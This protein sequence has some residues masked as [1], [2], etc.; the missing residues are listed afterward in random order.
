M[1]LLFTLTVFLNSFLLFL[2]EP[3]IA[4]RLLPIFGGS[5]LV[6]NT[7]LLFFQIVLVLGYLWAH[8][9]FKWFGP[10]RQPYAHLG[11]AVLPLLVMP[12]HLNEG[13]RSAYQNALSTNPNSLAA[14][15][16][17]MLLLMLLAS[18]GLPFFALS[19]G[20]PIIQR[21]FSH[22]DDPDAHNPYF[23]YAASN[24][25]SILALVFY[26]A[27]FERELGLSGQ[28]LW[29]SLG[30]VCFAVLLAFAARRGQAQEGP[31]K[32]DPMRSTEISWTQ[33]GLWVLLAAGPSALLLGVTGYVT[34]NIA[35]IPLLWV[36]PLA[37]YL[38][39]FIIVFGKWSERPGKV[40]RY[41]APF[42]A[43]PAAIMVAE[44][45]PHA[46][47]IYLPLH[48]VALFFIALACHSE[49]SLRK[50]QASHLTEFF[51]WVSI[52]GAVGGFFASIVAPLAL[53]SLAEYPWA[54]VICFV[55]I[56][57]SVK[58]KKSFILDAAIPLVAAFATAGLAKYLF[59]HAD[60]WKH[61][62]MDWV[63]LFGFFCLATSLRP[64]R[65]SLTLGAMLL[66]MNIVVER[67]DLIFRG[68]SFYGV[69]YV[70]AM[71]SQENPIAHRLTNGTT[72]HGSQ[73][74]NPKFQGQPTTYYS[75]P[76]GV[77]RAIVKRTSE[78]RLRHWAVVGLGTGTLAAYG[79]K[80]ESLDYYELDPSIEQIA[81]NP[82]LFTYLQN[83]QA[84]S[85]VLIGDARL[86]LTEIQ[87]GTYDLIALDAFA[88]DAIPVHLLTT[89]AFKLYERD[90]RADGWLLVH[91]SNR[92][93]D[94]APVVA[95]ICRANGLEGY[96]YDDNVNGKDMK[97]WG[98]YSNVLSALRLDP[99][100]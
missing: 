5:A 17:V 95:S 64:I 32:A 73:W 19:A 93:L 75:P 88:S 77:G 48:F 70:S 42:A 40:V 28:S 4:K 96:L 81:R 52:G 90:L 62:Q 92:Y 84:R 80:G 15:P 57:L 85:R 100:S 41:I 71:P 24:I 11:V 26:P 39:T 61:D 3:L 10:K 63:L 97:R 72:L 8:L 66:A 27:W 76:S 49:L 30:F 23:L 14:N 79:T 78:H 21:W 13:L 47:V 1:R 20:A 37:L 38:L 91:V 82:R 50:P 36:I 59:L 25:G 89:D 44:D 7:C 87:P 29:W 51:L 68:R 46:S 31:T 65:F 54:I 18:V 58:P 22:S 56:G 12:L 83:C 34:V 98:D 9:S 33:R 67:P 35:P 60:R 45:A 2:V 94:L 6:W 53:K 74:V 55:A 69:H 16:S 43:F 86:R 99:R